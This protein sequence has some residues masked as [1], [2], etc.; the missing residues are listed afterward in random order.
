MTILDTAYVCSSV[1]LVFD[2]KIYTSGLMNRRP[3]EQQYTLA[4][5]GKI[6]IE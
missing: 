5:I 2:E 1:I 4:K 6:L 3:S